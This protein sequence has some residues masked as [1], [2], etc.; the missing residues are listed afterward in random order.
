MSSRYD[1]MLDMPHHTSAVHPRMSMSDRAAQFAPFAALTGHDDIIAETARYVDS[2][3][4]ISEDVKAEVD[5]RLKIILSDKS[6]AENVTVTFFREDDKK[7][8]GAYLC[9]TGKIIK[10]DMNSKIIIMDS[11]LS[12]PINSIS[13]IDSSIFSKFDY[14]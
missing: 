14:T 13:D 2:E 6:F 9:A 10:A 4:E 12:I 8:G 3:I 1:Y 11:G 7:A 5:R